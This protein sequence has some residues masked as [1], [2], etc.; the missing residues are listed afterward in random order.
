MVTL[1]GAVFLLGGIA[2]EPRLHSVHQTWVKIQTRLAGLDDGGVYGRRAL[3]G[4][5]IFGVLG[6]TLGG[7]LA[8][9]WVDVFKFRRCAS[10]A[11]LLPAVCPLH[12]A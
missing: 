6:A 1:A 4:G 7:A 5:V 8:T 3:L 10:A 9:G 11:G 12:K 2:V